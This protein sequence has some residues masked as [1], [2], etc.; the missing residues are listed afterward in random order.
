MCYGGCAECADEYD[1]MCDCCGF[2]KKYK[3]GRYSVK[4]RSNTSST[5]HDPSNDIEMAKNQ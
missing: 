2:R 3:V 4:N 5:A 1:E